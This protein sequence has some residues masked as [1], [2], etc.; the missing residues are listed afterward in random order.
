MPL[1]IP[2]LYRFLGLVAVAVTVPAAVVACSAD[3]TPVTG[4]TSS[5]P[6]SATSPNPA[7]PTTTP[8]GT[9]TTAPPPAKDASIDAAKDSG[10]PPTDVVGSAECTAYCAMMTSKCSRDVRPGV[11]LRDPERPVRGF[12]AGLPRLPDDPWQ[13]VLRR[14]RLLHRLELLTQYFTLQV[15][16]V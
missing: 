14:R 1:S 8:T 15:G 16:E 3:V 9:G 13:L 6:P 2:A 5:P 11:R 4:G 12:D 10:P 7:R